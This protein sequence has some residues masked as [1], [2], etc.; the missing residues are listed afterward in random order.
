MRRALLAAGALLIFSAPA[1]ADEVTIEKRTIT[2]EATP[3][4]G[5]TVST[6]IIAP[7]APPAPEAEAPPPPPGPS[8]VWR[9]GHWYWNPERA[10]YV[11]HKGDYMEPP[12]T[13]AAW[14]PGRFI[15][16]AGGWVWE[17]GHW[18]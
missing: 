16:R 1:F 3:E 7:T 12:R 6:V 18:N 2:H 11:W 8:L 15:E 13:E 14:I 5:S 17:D 10:A 4:S 9:P